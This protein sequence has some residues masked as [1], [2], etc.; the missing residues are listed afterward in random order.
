MF[1]KTQSSAKKD[2]MNLQGKSA[3]GSWFVC[4]L[5]GQLV[6]FT[7]AALLVAHMMAP[8]A[9]LPMLFV[10]T[11]VGGFLGGL[12]GVKLKLRSLPV[13]KKP[14]RAYIFQ[15]LAETN[16]K[17]AEM[18][19]DEDFN[20]AANSNRAPKQERKAEPRL[21]PSPPRLGM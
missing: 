1:R 4:M 9:A 7:I 14:I 3:H 16:K 8:A 19:V 10:S 21:A 13:R 20:G 11:L 6:G 15:A 5:A 12:V 17:L 2:P 18:F